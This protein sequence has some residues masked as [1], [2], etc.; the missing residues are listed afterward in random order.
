M[1][2]AIIDA[3]S[4][5]FPRI[6]HFESYCFIKTIIGFLYMKEKMSLAQ[7]G[8]NIFSFLQTSKK[9]FHFNGSELLF[10]ILNKYV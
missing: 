4:V 7:Q 10:C 8:K 5:G 2:Q 9:A 6:E 3:S 1:K